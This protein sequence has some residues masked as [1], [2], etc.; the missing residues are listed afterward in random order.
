M[1]YD[2]YGAFLENSL[3]KLVKFVSSWKFSTYNLYDKCK[4]QES[5]WQTN[6]G[7]D[8]I[9]KDKNV[10]ANVKNHFANSDIATKLIFLT[11]GIEFKKHKLEAWK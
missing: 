2:L 10:W 1:K 5:K 4:D 3:S 6:H 8:A 11:H 9:P 7:D